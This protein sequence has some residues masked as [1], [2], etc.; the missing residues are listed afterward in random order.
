M[1]TMLSNMAAMIS[2]GATSPNAKLPLKP[3]YR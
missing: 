3:L 1:A 2:E